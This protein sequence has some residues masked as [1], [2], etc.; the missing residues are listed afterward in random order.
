MAVRGGHTQRERHGLTPGASIWRSD[1]SS[2]ARAVL[3]ISLPAWR[4][5][6]AMARI[7][8]MKAYFGAVRKFAALFPYL[9]GD[10][11][12]SGP[13]EVF[14]VRVRSSRQRP[15]PDDAR[16][17]WTGVILDA[18]VS[19]RWLHN[20]APRFTAST[21]RE[22]EHLAVADM[23]GPRLIVHVRRVPEL[24]PDDPL[25]RLADAEA[26][27]RAVLSDPGVAR[28]GRGA[29][30]AAREVLRKRP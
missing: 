1:D 19:R 12:C 21:F 23:P 24:I 4:S 7:H 16:R 15:F 2:E 25:R 27:L 17:G 22:L 9:K 13:A 14:I 3:T 10:A 6:E 8:G 18:L 11:G 28:L 26:A 5:V 30:T 29:V 20:A